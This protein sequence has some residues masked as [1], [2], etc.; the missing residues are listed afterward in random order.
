MVGSCEH[1]KELLGSLKC[2]EFQT[3]RMDDIVYSSCDSESLSARS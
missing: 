2:S 3:L 1:G